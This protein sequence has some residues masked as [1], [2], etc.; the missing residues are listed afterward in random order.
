[1]LWSVGSQRSVRGGQG[2]DP[3][4]ERTR[5]K[6]VE[7]LTDDRTELFACKRRQNRTHF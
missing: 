6:K 5:K 2:W 3:V 1:M 4:E 7:D